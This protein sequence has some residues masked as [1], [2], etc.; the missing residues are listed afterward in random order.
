M[1]AASEAPSAGALAGHS[2]G[3]VSQKSSSVAAAISS[4]KMYGFV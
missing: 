2:Y 1:A 3:N 4:S